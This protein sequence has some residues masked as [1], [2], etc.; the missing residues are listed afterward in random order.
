ANEVQALMKG[1]LHTDTIMRAVVARS[2]GLRTERRI[3]HVFHMTVPNS[4]KALMITDGAVN[5]APDERTLM[6]I[7]RNAVDLAHALGYARPKVAMLSGSESVIESMPSTV[8]AKRIVDRARGGEIT[9]ADVDGPFG[10]DNAVSPH[11]AEL[12]GITSPVA[13]KA[14][15]LAVPNI[16]MGN[17]LFK[18][19]VYFRSALAAGVVLGAKVPIVLTSRADPPEARLAASAIA[20]IRANFGA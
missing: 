9:D 12:K 8:L 3:S 17:G 11:A 1:Q 15:I 4:E 6:D 13:G 19:L 5:V 2:A 7:V 14:D 18:M 10:F 16:E 20:Q